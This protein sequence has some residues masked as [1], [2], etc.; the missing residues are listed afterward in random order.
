EKSSWAVVLFWFLTPIV[1]WSFSA[2]M[3]ENLITITYLLG[4]YSAIRY[5]TSESYKFRWLI[6]IVFCTIAG[7]LIKGPVGLLPLCFPFI[8]NWQ[9]K[10]DLKKSI[11]S[12]LVVVLTFIVL[13]ILLL[14][15]PGLKNNLQVYYDTQITGSLSG[16]RVVVHR[17]YI[18]ERLFLEILP[19]FVVFGLYF[20]IRIKKISSLSQKN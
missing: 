13:F 1:F 9:K 4:L 10:G 14:Q 2:N 19:A 8:L 12:G 6:Y 17:T 16:D 11:S 18:L 20:L 15:I 3:L 5:T 7:V